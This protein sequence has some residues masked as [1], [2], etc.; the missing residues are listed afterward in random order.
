[1]GQWPE[2]DRQLEGFA[3]PAPPAAARAIRS[4]H[5]RIPFPEQTDL[6]SSISLMSNYKLYNRAGLRLNIAKSWAT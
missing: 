4:V 3:V 1:M 2:I 5:P 6:R